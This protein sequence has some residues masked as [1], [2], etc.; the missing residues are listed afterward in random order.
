[1]AD[2]IDRVAS[3]CRDAMGVS[4]LRTDEDLVSRGAD[5]V[6]AVEVVSRL[7]LDY[8]IDTIDVFFA[9]PTIGALAAAVQSHLKNQHHSPA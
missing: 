1:M 6:V 2:I 9:T 7:E 4:D 5:S 3:I 8:G